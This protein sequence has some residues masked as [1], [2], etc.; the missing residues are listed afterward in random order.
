[1]SSS[2]LKNGAWL[3]QSQGTSLS[4]GRYLNYHGTWALKTS[5]PALAGTAYKQ[6]IKKRHTEFVFKC[7]RGLTVNEFND[8]FT[9][10]RSS[11]ERRRNQDIILPSPETNII[12]NSL[13][14]RWAIEWNSLGSNVSM[15]LTSSIAIFKQNISKFNAG[16][17]MFDPNVAVTQHRDLN[18]L[19]F[20]ILFLT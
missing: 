5:T 1:M 17:I 18:F 8:L 16:K 9:Q 7:I 12:R 2:P 6:F 13:S 19:Y 20:Y 14:Y 10:R 11:R 3:T 15:S 4:I